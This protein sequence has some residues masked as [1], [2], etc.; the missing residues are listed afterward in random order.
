MYSCNALYTSVKDDGHYMLVCTTLMSFRNITGSA[1]EIQ[2]SQSLSKNFADGIGHA[3]NLTIVKLA[4][5]F[6]TVVWIHW[7]FPSFWKPDIF[8]GN[9]RRNVRK[10]KGIH[11]LLCCFTAFS[12]SHRWLCLTSL[13]PRLGEGVASGFNF[14]AHAVWCGFGGRQKKFGQVGFSTWHALLSAHINQR[15][16]FF[17]GW[18]ND[19][20]CNF[21]GKGEDR[22]EALKS[23]DHGNSLSRIIPIVSTIWPW[24]NQSSTC[25]QHN[26]AHCTVSFLIWFTLSTCRALKLLQKRKGNPCKFDLPEKRRGKIEGGMNATLCKK[27]RSTLSLWIFRSCFCVYCCT[28]QWSCFQRTFMMLCMPLESVGAGILSKRKF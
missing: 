10:K 5:R 7:S 1:W 13:T 26:Q 21:T 6:I 20:H 25:I 17:K 24:E 8:S 15:Q 2:R 3:S 19:R 28:L 16:L 23:V 9:E 14:Q 22:S 12:C 4:E 27:M 18:H 11:L